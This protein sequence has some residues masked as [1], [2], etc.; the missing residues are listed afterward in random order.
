MPA[1]QVSPTVRTHPDGP[2]SDARVY[3]AKK[4]KKWQEGMSHACTDR[5]GR[6][7]RGSQCRACPRGRRPENRVLYTQLQCLQAH[8]VREMGE[9]WGTA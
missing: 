3:Y 9:D 1:D 4:K 6:G 7:V 2:C 5:E 8:V